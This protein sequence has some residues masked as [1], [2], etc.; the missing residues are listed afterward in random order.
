MDELAHRVLVGEYEGP[1][2]WTESVAWFEL[3]KAKRGEL[4][5]GTTTFSNCRERLLAKQMIRMWETAKNKFYQAVFDGREVA[6]ERPSAAR[7]S[8]SYAYLNPDGCWRAALG[9]ALNGPSL[10]LVRTLGEADSHLALMSEAIQQV[11]QNNQKK[12]RRG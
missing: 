1:E 9:P 3:T 2:S 6:P 5:L 11:D 7:P 12:R 4:G 10:D 8:E